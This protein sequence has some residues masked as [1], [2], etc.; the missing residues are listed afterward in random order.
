MITKKPTNTQR[1]AKVEGVVAQLY[2]LM[3]DLNK[4]LTALDGGVKK[5]AKDEEK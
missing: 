4:R 1:I 2:M 3:T 5:V